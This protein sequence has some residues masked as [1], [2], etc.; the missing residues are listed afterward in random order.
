VA[1]V[2][3]WQLWRGGCCGELAVVKEVAVVKRWPLG[4]GGVSHGRILFGI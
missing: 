2:E 4:R 3:R 1:V